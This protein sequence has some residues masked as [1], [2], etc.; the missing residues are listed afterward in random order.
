MIWVWHEASCYLYLM[1]DAYSLIFPSFVKELVGRFPYT[2]KK[3]SIWDNHHSCMKERNQKKLHKFWFLKAKTTW[4]GNE[5]DTFIH[6]PWTIIWQLWTTAW[7]H[8]FPKSSKPPQQKGHIIFVEG[9]ER[10]HPW[11]LK[12]LP[13]KSYRTPQ[14][15]KDRWFNHHFWCLNSRTLRRPR[16]VVPAIAWTWLTFSGTYAMANAVR[17]CCTA[18]SVAPAVYVAWAETLGS[19]VV[20]LGQCPWWPLK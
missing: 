2:F 4:I 16:S 9:H 7:T 15:G 5:N 11:S 10:N 1:F 14:K 6:H 12:K 13:L 17:S 19:S 8:L 20:W 3:R 18:W